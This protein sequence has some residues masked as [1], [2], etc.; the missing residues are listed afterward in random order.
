MSKFKCCLCDKEVEG[1]GNNPRPLPI[2][3]ENDQCCDEC[4][5]TKV[6]PAR[7]ELLIKKNETNE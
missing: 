7:I 5:Q 6:I 1:Y 3:N 2:K 4:N